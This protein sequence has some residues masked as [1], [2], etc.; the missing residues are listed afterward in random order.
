MKIG[1]FH[2]RF[3]RAPIFRLAALLLVAL[4]FSCRP[5]PPVTSADTDKWFV[6]AKGKLAEVSVERVLYESAPTEYFLIHIRVA[7]QTDRP[8]GIDLREK[9]SAVYA[10]QWGYDSQVRGSMDERRIIRKSLTHKEQA[11][12][13]AEFANGKL[14]SI[15]AKQSVDY[16]EIFSASSAQDVKTTPQDKYLIIALDGEQ[17]ITDGKTVEQL[18]LE[19]EHGLGPAKHG[20][21]HRLLVI[22]TPVPW[23]A[24]PAKAHVIHKAYEII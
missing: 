22:P 21:N 2:G 5:S 7:N 11:Q 24:L 4:A 6:V 14:T 13:K 9:W 8:L 19:W 15:P 10:N 16:F 23:E 17:R 20:E 1:Y 12:L 18:L 3:L